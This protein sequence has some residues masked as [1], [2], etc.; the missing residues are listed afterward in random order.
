MQE[1][2]KRRRLYT[3]TLG[4]KYERKWDTPNPVRLLEKIG[5][6]AK[7]VRTTLTGV[8]RSA[9][10]VMKEIGKD[11]AFKETLLSIIGY[12]YFS[13]SKIELYA[14]PADL[15]LIHVIIKGCEYEILDPEELPAYMR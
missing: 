12:T 8:F 3:F 15:E 9:V 2:R 10:D 1:N 4:A 5:I 7:I 14:Y 6:Q 13:L 11:K